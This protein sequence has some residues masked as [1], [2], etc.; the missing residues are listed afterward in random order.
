MKLIYLFR[1]TEVGELEKT[2][3]NTYVYNSYVE[4]E[5]KLLNT[6]GAFKASNY[7]LWNSSNRESATLFYPFKDLIADF[8]KKNLI[9]AAAKITGKESEWEQL[10]KLASLKYF[11]TDF[12]VQ[13]ADEACAPP[14]L[15][16]TITGS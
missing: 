3:R 16:D 8:S 2:D 11:A 10:V 7:S 9:R 12:Y 14:P 15:S 5:Q 4:N 6:S 13:L 1:G